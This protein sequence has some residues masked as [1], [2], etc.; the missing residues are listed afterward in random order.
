LHIFAVTGL[1]VCFSS[2]AP[3]QSVSKEYQI[4]AA[5]LKRI[6]S[7]VQWP[8]AQIQ[9]AKM[10]FRFCVLGDF[11]FGM[12]LAHEIGGAPIAGRKV[13]LHRIQTEQMRTCDLI[14][15]SR[16]E[17]KHLVKILGDLRG[18]TIL[19]IGESTGFL[20]AGGIFELIYEGDSV[21]MNVNLTAARQAQ[22]RLDA[23]LLALAKRVV[24]AKEQPGT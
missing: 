22:L 3:G 11:S 10:P 16:S 14:F 1:F 20:E 18:L 6:P 17:S 13:E 24:V 7:F 23:R 5:Y 21:Q 12:A 8:E 15:F 19:T 4:K 9:G 2:P